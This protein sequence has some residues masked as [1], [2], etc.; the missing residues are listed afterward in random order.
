MSEV[1]ELYPNNTKRIELVVREPVAGETTSPVTG[2]AP[3]VRLVLTPTATADLHASL[4]VT[5]L[6]YATT[7]E[8][9][10]DLPGA[11]IAARLDDATLTYGKCYVQVLIGTTLVGVA[12]AVI[13]RYRRLAVTLPS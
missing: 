13:R 9:Y 11:A 2:L 1:I 6:E 8:Y 12:D 5:A 4:T 10:A 7:G 3:T